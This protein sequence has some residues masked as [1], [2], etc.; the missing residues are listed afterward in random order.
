MAFQIDI[1]NVIAAIA[2]FFSGYAALTTRK[3]NE[4][5]KSLIKSQEKLNTLLLEKEVIERINDKK[6]DLDA[7]FIKMGSNAYRLKIWN[8]GKSSARN[9]NIEFPDGDKIVEQREIDAKFPLETL[10]MHQSV[11]LV[12][13]AHFG[14][15]R[16]Y[17]IKLTWSDDFGDHHEKVLYP[18]I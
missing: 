18:T 11:G 6:A 7:S 9:L 8:N 12:A 5:Q 16:K 15:K 2:L 17:T 10:G 13:F 1:G 3:F 4:R 14:T